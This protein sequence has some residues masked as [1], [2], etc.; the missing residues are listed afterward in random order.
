MSIHIVV[1]AVA[2]EAA[3]VGDVG[4][5]G[6]LALQLGLRLLLG[7]VDL[8][9]AGAFVEREGDLQLR[10][11]AVDLQGDGVTAALRSVKELISR[12]S[13]CRMM[14]R[15]CSPAVSAQLPSVTV[16][17]CGPAGRL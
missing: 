17:I 10:A 15:G 11:G 13:N 5:G 6:G 7:R 8:A 3:E 9:L 2:L 16:T 4:V 14:S 1:V 12:S